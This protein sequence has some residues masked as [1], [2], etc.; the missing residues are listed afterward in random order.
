MKRILLTIAYDGTNYCGWQKQKMP[1]VPTV[2]LAVEKACR[3][4]FHNDTLECIGAS[5][6]DTGVHALGQRAVIDVETTIPTERIPLAIRGYLPEDIV[7]T[8]AQEMPREFHPRYDC[9]KKTYVYKILNSDFK[10]P[11]L[12][13]YSEWVC[14]K[15]D[16]LSM[17]KAAKQLIGTHDFKAFCAAGSSV[18]TTVR[19]V[20]ECDVT[21][22]DECVLISI[23]G[24]GFLYNM[25]RII[26]GTLI[27][28]GLGK[29]SSEEIPI[30]LQCRDRAKAGKTAGAQG[31]TLMT[32]YYDSSVK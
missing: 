13:N 6:T 19:T 2:E 29:I 7:V 11:I 30:I 8:Q 12:R 16:I 9:T 3:I 20:Y 10:N 5:R 17:D 14:K 4:L 27:Q 26:A 25:V 21:Q 1:Q 15:L 18:K 31:L 23:T 28:V 32:I 22:Q 24:N